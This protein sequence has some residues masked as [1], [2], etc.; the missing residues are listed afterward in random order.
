[1]PKKEY[2]GDSVYVD[3][4]HGGL[5]LTTENGYGPSNTIFLEPEVYGALLE[6]VSRLKTNVQKM[7]STELEL[8]RQNQEAAAEWTEPRFEEE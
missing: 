5:E 3:V 6:Y 4:K 2:L 1:M 7:D 8:R